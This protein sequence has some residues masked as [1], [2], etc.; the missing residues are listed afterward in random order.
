LLKTATQEL[1]IPM[2]SFAKSLPAAMAMAMALVLLAAGCNEQ[3]GHP[4]GDSE[5]DSAKSAAGTALTPPAGEPV[6][7]AETPGAQES[8]ASDALVALLDAYMERSAVSSPFLAAL[9]GKPVKKLPDPTLAA[10]QADAGFAAGLLQELQA[11][12]TA[13]LDHQQQLT[14]AMLQRQRELMQEQAEFYWQGFSLTPYQ[15]GFI[16]SSILPTAL[17]SAPLD[18]AEDVDAYLALVADIGR[19]VNDQADKLEGQAE[20]GV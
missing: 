3:S 7:G 2:K 1:A 16:F 5:R 17:R 8:A 12:D 18:S 4:A 19:F 6:S 11:I 13:S 15:A 9:S 14:A 20:R 10:Q